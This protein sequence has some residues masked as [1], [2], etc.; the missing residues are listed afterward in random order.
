MGGNYETHTLLAVVCRATFDAR[1]LANLN[2]ATRFCRPPQPST[3]YK[4]L[5]KRINGIIDDGA[6][7]V[8]PQTGENRTSVQ[9]KDLDLDGED[10]AIAS[11]ARPAIPTSSMCMYLKRMAPNIRPSQRDR[12]RRADR[13]GVLPHPAAHRGKGH[14]SC[15]GNS[16]A[17]AP[18]RHDG[19]LLP[20]RRT[21]DPARNHLYGR[22]S[23]PIWIPM[24]PTIWSCSRPTRPTAASPSYT[25]TRTTN[26]NLRVKP[27]FPPKANGRQPENGLAARLSAGRLCR[28]QTGTKRRPDD[29]Y[30]H[31]R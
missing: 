15:P 7:Q 9:L 31:L 10:E 19:M 4:S 22:S 28:K 27:R 21:Q 16:A 6:V 13:L 14:H 20:G 23:L 12:H 25:A 18:C 24:A 11:S 5:Q 29:R 2:R 17:K 3:T 26:W 30:L 1:R 8:A